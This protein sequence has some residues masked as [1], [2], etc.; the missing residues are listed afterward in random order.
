MLYQYRGKLT[1]EALG[2]LEDLLAKGC[3]KFTP[4]ADFND[5]FDCC[6]TT[7]TDV[8]ASALPPNVAC[9]SVNRGVQAGISST[10]GVACFTPHADSMLM[11]SHYGD[12]HRSVCVGIDSNELATN[13]PRN[14][15]G[16][17]LYHGPEAVPLRRGKKAAGRPS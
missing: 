16:N 6:P 17:P 3:L 10:H 15:R 14:D 7:F 1:D 13:V 5:P 2:Y 4:P 9:D 11:W 12:Q 8:P